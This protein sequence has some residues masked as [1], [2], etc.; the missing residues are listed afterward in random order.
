MSEILEQASSK[1]DKAISALER[2]YASIRTGRATPALLDRVHAMYYGSPTPIN[3]MATVSVQEGRTLVIKPFDPSTIKDI[4]KGIAAS[5]IGI[6]PQND[7]QIIR[8][9]IPPLTEDRRKE[10][11]KTASKMA[12]EA[13]VA[14]RNIRRDA[15]EAIKK[16]D[17]PEDVAKGLQDEVQK[18][19]DKFV[20]K[21]DELFKE[22]E[23]DI[24]TV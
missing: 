23:K 5:D 19:T 21:V 3:Q 15:N 18:L 24:L 12:E 22:K 10:Y 17:E 11:V 4:E 7:G 8:L 9:N 14:L 2:E 6:T 1:M 13:R 20:K 16:S